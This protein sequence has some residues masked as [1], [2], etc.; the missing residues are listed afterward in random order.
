VTAVNPRGAHGSHRDRDQACPVGGF[1]A[2]SRRFAEVTALSAARVWS[3]L[4]VL[5]YVGLVALGT[6][7]RIDD[8]PRLAAALAGFV[9][10]DVATWVVL[11]LLDLPGLI[12]EDAWDAVVNA[13]GGILILKYCGLQ[14]WTDTANLDAAFLT[15]LLVVAVK[16]AWTFVTRYAGE[17][18]ET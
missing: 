3:A 17:A 9:V 2:E 11:L 7:R 14:V 12:W 6:S 1:A 8:S 18:G 15:F 16:I 4:R 5:F 13:I 10:A